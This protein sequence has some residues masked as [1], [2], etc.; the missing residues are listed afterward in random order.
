MINRFTSTAYAFVLTAVFLI[1]SASM[2]FPAHAQSVQ[3]EFETATQ[4]V[5]ADQ[6][7]AFQTGDHERAFSHAD[8]TV[9]AI[10]RDTA[11]FIRMVKSGY[12]PLYNPDNYIFGRNFNMDG[13]I[14]Q[15][16][17]ATDEK[18]KQWQA[19]YTLRQG[20]DGIWKI[21]GVKM[22][23]YTGAAT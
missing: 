21:T 8:D 22:E 19:V 2:Y 7:N 12:Q 16:V 18:G 17:I 14:H 11:N 5:I 13:T 20:S 10:F 9:R 6:I 4:Q 23:P 1:S 3:P 15:E